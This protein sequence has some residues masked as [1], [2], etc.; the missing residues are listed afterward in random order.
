MK[1]RICSTALVLT[2]LL[3]LCVPVMAADITLKVVAPEGQITAGES[4]AVSVE[5]S[6]NPG[7]N[8]FAMTLAYDAEKMTCDVAKGGELLENMMFV[9]NPSGDTGAIVTGVSV[10]PMDQNGELALFKFTANTDLE[11]VSF[12]LEDLSFTDAEGTEISVEVAEEQVELETPKDEDFVTTG[13]DGTDV[14]TGEFEMTPEEME[15]A[16]NPEPPAPAEEAETPGEA[17]AQE[18]VQG[19]DEAAPAETA[20]D[21]AV[22]PEAEASD[23]E[24]TTE[25]VASAPGSE[26]EGSETGITSNEDESGS[27]SASKE[28]KSGPI[29]WIVIAV[30]VIAVAAVA[31]VVVKK[32]KE[33]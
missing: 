6:G 10:T 4:F 29:L 27:D 23:G 14:G 2:M 15:A 3:A 24:K 17:P 8:T 13:D 31:A 33:N 28:T 5:I 22:A 26:A 20:G 12:T 19:D 11:N 18:E 7:I 16:L 9:T 32:N 21:T 1:L 30:I 25:T